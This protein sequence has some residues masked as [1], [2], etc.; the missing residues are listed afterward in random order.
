MTTLESALNNNLDSLSSLFEFNA[1]TSSNDIRVLAH[2][3]NAPTSF[4]LDVNVDSSG[5]V[6]SASV[7]G[8]L[9]LFEISGTRI[10]G[11]TGTAYGGFS[12]SFAG[13]WSES[14]DFTLSYGL[15][16]KVYSDSN[17]V[18]NATN[19]SLVDVIN[20]IEQQDT[21]LSNESARI[22]SDAETY[23]TQLTNRYAKIESAILSTKS[24][25]SYLKQLSGSSSSSG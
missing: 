23:R 14:I 11:K 13:S 24:T 12:F 9:S 7:N 4:T 16:D 2:G 15:A 17:A 22:K 5:S 10:I 6:T 20:N 18:G 3:S 25:I 8:D 1:T 19:G 21:T